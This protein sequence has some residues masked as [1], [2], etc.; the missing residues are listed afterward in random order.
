MNRQKQSPDEFIAAIDW[1]NAFRAQAIRTIPDIPVVMSAGFAGGSGRTKA[2][3]ASH[4]LSRFVTSP[5]A[6]TAASGPGA[7]DNR[8]GE[9]H[10]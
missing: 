3:R 2:V 10:R 8:W 6:A 5:A 1:G 4:W 7:T 9:K